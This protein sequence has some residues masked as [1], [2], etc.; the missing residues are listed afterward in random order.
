M[1]GQPRF[2]ST[3]EKHV[4]NENIRVSTEQV[5]QVDEDFIGG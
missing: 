1:A 4:Q 2:P 5:N 3:K